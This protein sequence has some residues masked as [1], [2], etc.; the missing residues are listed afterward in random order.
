MQKKYKTNLLRTAAVIASAVILTLA[1]RGLRADGTCQCWNGVANSSEWQYYGCDT[2]EGECS[3][4]CHDNG[5]KFLNYTSYN[6]EFNTTCQ[7]PAQFRNAC[8]MDNNG[9]WEPAMPVMCWCGDPD[10]THGSLSLCSDIALGKAQNGVGRTQGS[11]NTKASAPAK[12]QE[13]RK[14]KGPTGATKK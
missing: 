13:S 2:S 11:L 10:Q 8:V 7:S 4:H 5:Y 6:I 14:F 9:G 3:A 12:Q 1:D